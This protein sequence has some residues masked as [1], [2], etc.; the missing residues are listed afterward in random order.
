MTPS[1]HCL[2]GLHLGGNEDAKCA[3]NQAGVKRSGEVGR[4]A[5]IAARP[6]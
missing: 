3:S 2:C 1:L 5:E 4:V 6:P